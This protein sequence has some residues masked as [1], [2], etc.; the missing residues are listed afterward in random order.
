MFVCVFVCLCLW[1]FLFFFEN[2]EKMRAEGKLP[3]YAIW[4]AG[5]PCVDHQTLHTTCIMLIILAPLSF[6]LP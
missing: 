4:E 5:E 2:R 6:Y 1:F 3:D